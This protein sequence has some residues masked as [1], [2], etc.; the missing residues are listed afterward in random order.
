[1]MN[2]RIIDT[3]HEQ[4]DDVE[5]FAQPGDQFRDHIAF[6]QSEGLLCEVAVND[7]G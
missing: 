2:V 6:S 4:T 1:L 7:G 3:A 5:P